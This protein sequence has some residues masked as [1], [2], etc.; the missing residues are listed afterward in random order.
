MLNAQATQFRLDENGRILYQPDASNP[1][2]G[3]PVAQ[4]VKGAGILEPGLE[5]TAADADKTAL[6]NWLKTHIATVLEPL[7]ALKIDETLQGPV[8]GIALKVYEAMGI[9]PREE[10]ED[11]IG[12]L[13][14]DTRRVLRAKKIRL[15]P[16]LV[17]QPDLNKPAAVRLRAVLWTLFNE[18]SLPPEMPKDGVVSFKIE[19]DKIDRAYQQ[20][21]GYPVYGSRAI[22]IDMLDRVIN[23]VYEGAQ[24]GKFQAK[25]EM[26][27]WL[28]CKIEDLYE[29]LFAMGHRKIYDPAHNETEK[30]MEEKSAEE[31]PAETEVPV[32]AVVP[33]PQVKPELA[34]FLLKKG[35]A[36]EKPAAR[37]AK[38]RPEKKEYIPRPKKSDHKKGAKHGEK[39]EPRER[40]ISA[41]AKINPE[42]SPFAI[43]QQLKVKKDAG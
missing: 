18:K 42:D 39:R 41:A 14:Q 4:L 33:R 10:L 34:T 30:A 32:E 36:F 40:V 26:A 9:V 23:A 12:Q 8:Q 21:I 13:D 37:E 27:E 11:L 25:H 15:G 17:F 29:I 35:K 5:V 16:V 43:L 22:R 7:V 38:P 19:P 31:K 2:P 20:A 28:G 3:S 24:G 6:E 1:L